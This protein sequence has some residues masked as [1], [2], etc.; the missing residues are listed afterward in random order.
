[1]G[2]GSE[3]NYG[4]ITPLFRRAAFARMRPYLK[5]KGRKPFRR[6]IFSAT[7]CRGRADAWEDGDQDGA[8]AFGGS[9]E[10]CPP[11]LLDFAARDPRCVRATFSIWPCSGAGGLHCGVSGFILLTE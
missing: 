4:A 2:H 1:V 8:A 3:G 9:F 7:I 5:L 6:V 11:S 10:K